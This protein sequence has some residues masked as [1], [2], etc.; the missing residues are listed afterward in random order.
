MPTV[1]VL[2]W[3]LIASIGRVSS[4]IAS[5]ERGVRSSTTALGVPTLPYSIWYASSGATPQWRS[6]TAT[7]V[8]PRCWLRGGR[9]RRPLAARRR[10]ARAPG[11]SRGREPAE[12]PVA[13]DR[14]LATAALDGSRGPRAAG[15]L[16]RR[17][18][19]P[20]RTRTGGRPSRD[21][22]NASDGCTAGTEIACERRGEPLVAVGRDHDRRGLVRAVDRDLLGDVVGVRARQA[23]RAD[24]D[25]RLGR[26]VDVL[27]VLGGVAGDRLVAELGELDAQLLG[28]DAVARRCPRPPSSGA[29]A[30][31]AARPRRSRA[32]GA[33][34]CCIASGRSRSASQQVVGRSGGRARRRRRRSRRRAGSRPRPAR[35]TPSSTRRS[36]RRRGRRTCRARR[37][38]CR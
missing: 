34:T 25:Q 8:A 22:T 19:A 37:R 28:G 5:R 21:S 35:R 29:P 23:G 33:S 32:G 14:R 27:L 24:E 1:T 3:C 20:P 7:R 15:G 36:S 6:G 11:S 10:S 16:A 2:A 18:R 38:T 26:E 31:A 17:W 13:G 9:R 12:Q 30:R 4:S